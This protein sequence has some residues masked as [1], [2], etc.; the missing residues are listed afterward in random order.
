MMASLVGVGAVATAALGK[1]AA[2]VALQLLVGFVVGGVGG[3]LMVR[4]IP[5]VHLPAAGGAPCAS[6]C[7]PSRREE[8]RAYGHSVSPARGTGAAGSAREGIDDGGKPAQPVAPSKACT[9]ASPKAARS[10]GLRLVTSV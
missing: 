8:E 1:V 5:R 4:C 3:R 7:A 10:P 9:R 6:S 2:G